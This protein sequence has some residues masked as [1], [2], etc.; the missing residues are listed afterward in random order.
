[1]FCQI[2]GVTSRSDG[3]LGIGL[4]LVKGL[5]ELHGGTVEARSGGLGHGSEFI[6]R[7]PFAPRHPAPPPLMTDPALA[8]SVRRRILVADD[9]KD[10]AESISMLLELA[11]HEVAQDLRRQPWGT[12]IQLIA[13]TGW[14]QEN[15]RRLALEAGF[16]HH[17]IAT[18]RD[19]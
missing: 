11:G 3:G 2:E 1:M 17:V 19:T 6:V 18:W 9:N 4:A 8:A 10:A 7:L 12:K 13:L 15:D 16:D 14:G 5:T